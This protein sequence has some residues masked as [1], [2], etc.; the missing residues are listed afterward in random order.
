[1]SADEPTKPYVYQPFG[2]AD[3]AHWEAGRIYGVGFP[4][5]THQMLTTVRPLITDAIAKINAAL[6]LANTGGTENG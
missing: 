2:M 3:K 6:L 5:A 4:Y 1:M